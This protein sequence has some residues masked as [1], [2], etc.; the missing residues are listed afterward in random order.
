MVYNVES[1][2]PSITEDIT[3]NSKYDKVGKVKNFN[4]SQNNK[5]TK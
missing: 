4:S 1:N 3:L 5:V 2:N